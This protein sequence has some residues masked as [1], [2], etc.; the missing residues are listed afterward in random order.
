MKH[1]DF[2][3]NFKRIRNHLKLEITTALKAHGGLYTWNEEDER[4]IVAANPDNA[5]PSPLDVCIISLKLEG[6]SI[7]IDAYDNEYGNGVSI[8]IDDIFIEHL[9]FILDYIPETTNVSDVSIPC[10]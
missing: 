3:N 4:P 8:D 1:S 2:N 6:E 5:T 10:E 9:S 7:V